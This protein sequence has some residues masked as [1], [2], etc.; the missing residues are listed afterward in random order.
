MMRA[1]DRSRLAVVSAVTT[2]RR[3]DRLSAVLIDLAWACPSAYLSRDLA[4]ASDSA[5]EREWR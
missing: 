2:R 1:G 4:V 5:A 3:P